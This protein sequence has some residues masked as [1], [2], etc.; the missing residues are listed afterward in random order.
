M[1]TAT[2]PPSPRKTRSCSHSVPAKAEAETTPFP[3]ETPAVPDVAVMQASSMEP[4]APPHAL[5]EKRRRHKLTDQQLQRLE[6]LYQAN[7]HPSRD[8]KDALA[9]EIDMTLKSVMIWFQNRRQDRRRKAHTA[10]ALGKGLTASSTPETTTSP[11]PQPA[12]PRVTPRKRPT[13]PLPTRAEKRAK[14]TT[15]TKTSAQAGSI[16]VTPPGPRNET[17]TQTIRLPGSAV[18]ATSGSETTM[19]IRIPKPPAPPAKSRSRHTNAS[20]G[21][22]KV[23]RSTITG[24]STSHPTRTQSQGLSR[25]THPAA[26][27]EITIS[28]G[29]EDSLVDKPPS[30]GALTLQALLQ[31][32]VASSRSSSVTV[33]D[34]SGDGFRHVHF[35]A[36]SPPSPQ[37]SHSNATTFTFD[38][39]SLSTLPLSNSSNTPPAA[40][41]TYQPSLEWACA[42]SAARRKHGLLVYRDEDDSSGE[43]SDFEDD[44]AAHHCRRIG[45]DTLRPSKRRRLHIPEEYHA[46]CSPDLVLGATLLLGLKHSIDLL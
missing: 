16:E 21:K 23:P 42:N 29:S 14:L 10:A 34:S 43:S 44:L 22:P 5:P 1:T 37:H 4:V 13:K 26:P 7:T 8:D 30:H 36:S 20:S 33:R 3:D 28:S 35:K 11:T 31:P 41:R 15:S 46:I 9:K 25:A 24:T 2:P 18:A 40:H 27:P 17:Q 19:R 6:E 12:G 39:P 45:K 38:S 32:P